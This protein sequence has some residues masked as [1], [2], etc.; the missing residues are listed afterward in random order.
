METILKSSRV[1]FL[2]QNKEKTDKQ[3]TKLLNIENQLVVLEWRWVEGLRI[4]STLIS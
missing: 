3:K 4:T 1:C 2:K